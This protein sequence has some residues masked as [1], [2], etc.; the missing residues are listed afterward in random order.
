MNVL[1]RYILVA[2]LIQ[3]EERSSLPRFGSNSRHDVL[4]SIRRIFPRYIDG[5][6]D[7][8]TKRTLPQLGLQEI[9]MI[10]GSVAEEKFRVD[11]ELFSAFLVQLGFRGTNDLKE[12]QRTPQLD[13]PI[14]RVPI[15]TASTEGIDKIQHDAVYAGVRCERLEIEPNVLFNDVQLLQ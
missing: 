9:D 15:D 8:F 5:L 4:Q 3:Y 11:S 2:A 14:C 13:L 7:I 12:S 1:H 10:F 6:A